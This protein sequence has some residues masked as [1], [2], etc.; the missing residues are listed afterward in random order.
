MANLCSV[1]YKCTGDPKEIQELLSVLIANEERK[2]PLVKNG[3]GKLWLGCIITALGGNWEEV[4]C[5]GE[6]TGYEMQDETLVIWQDTCW[7]EQEEFRH[8]LQKR[9]PSL[10]ITYR[11]EECGCEVFHTNSFADFPERYLLD[12]YDEP[13]YWKTIEEAAKYVS[14]LVGYE[15]EPNTDAITTALDNYQNEQEQQGHEVFYSFH[16]FTEVDD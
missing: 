14:N 11:E 7:S 12:T 2:D 9:F 6:V 5:R 10:T 8:Y 4:R 13:Q 1:T 16:E 3:F 15:I